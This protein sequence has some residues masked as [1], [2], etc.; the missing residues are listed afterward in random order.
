MCSP[1]WSAARLRG[2]SLAGA[3]LPRESSAR[4]RGSARKGDGSGGG[5]AHYYKEG[6]RIDDVIGSL[7]RRATRCCY[8]WGQRNRCGNRARV[9]GA[10]GE[11]DAHV[12]VDG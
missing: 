3:V 5:G 6:A 4:A 11:V 10:W 9:S 7:P 2:N 12:P 1:C 8:W